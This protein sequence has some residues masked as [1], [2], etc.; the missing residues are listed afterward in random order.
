MKPFVQHRAWWSP[1]L[2]VSAPRI[3]K[4]FSIADWSK[5]PLNTS[6]LSFSH[7]T[8]S[9]WPLG[10]PES[11]IASLRRGRGIT[12][13]VRLMPL[14]QTALGIHQQGDSA[15]ERAGVRR[16]WPPDHGSK[17]LFLWKPAFKSVVIVWKIS[18]RSFSPLEFWTRNTFSFPSH[19]LIFCSSSFFISLICHCK[20]GYSLGGQ[21]KHKTEKRDACV[22]FLLNS[23]LI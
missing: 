21:R 9:P 17:C 14:P 8:W 22:S 5:S 4:L 2:C 7:C 20:T 11:T 12:R 6:R 3:E 19:S 16:Q 15:E 23:Y 10:C 13:A 1:Y 18:W